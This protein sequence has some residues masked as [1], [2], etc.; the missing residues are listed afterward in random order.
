MTRETEGPLPQP[1]SSMDRPPD[2]DR[3]TTAQLKADINSG[4]T[5][6]KVGAFDPGLATLGTDDEAAGTP[7]SREAIAIARR[8]EVHSRPAA[9][10]KPWAWTPSGSGSLAWVI[11]AVAVALVGIFSLALGF[12]KT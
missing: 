1:T 4:E 11:A 9:A 6:D 8:E 2:S 10:K 5:G 7:P 12:M 3:P